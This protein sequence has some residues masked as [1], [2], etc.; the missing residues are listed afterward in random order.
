MRNRKHLSQGNIN[1]NINITSAKKAESSFHKISNLVIN[2]TPTFKT[3][4]EGF[5]EEGK[6]DKAS[7]Q[8]N[9]KKKTENLL[10]SKYSSEFVDNVD[11]K[12]IF[13]RRASHV[14]NKSKNFSEKNGFKKSK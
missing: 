10:Y 6:S 5:G 14:S 2:R 12:S 8:K 9:F 4:N 3:S 7:F 11:M 13:K 1:I